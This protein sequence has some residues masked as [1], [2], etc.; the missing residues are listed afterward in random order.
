MGSFF[1]RIFRKTPKTELFKSY[2]SRF[3]AIVGIGFVLLAAP[4][5]AQFVYVANE[6]GDNVSA[7]S[8]ATNGALTP[9]PGSPFPGPARSRLS[10]CG[11]IW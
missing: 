3:A 8:I 2:T 9:V 5:R 6:I 11:P 7:Y 1:D 4:L 10:S